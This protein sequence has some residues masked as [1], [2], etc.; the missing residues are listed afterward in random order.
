MKFWQQ[1]IV[2]I[3]AGI[4]LFI[5]FGPKQS[6]PHNPTIQG[7]LLK[8]GDRVFVFGGHSMNPKWLDGKEGYAGILEQFI[9]GQN[10]MPAAVIRMNESITAE[11]ISGEVL[12]LSLRYANATWQ[13]GAIVHLE[14]C[15]FEPDSTQ[16]QDRRKGK[17]IE[18]A[19]SIRLLKE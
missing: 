4:M 18:S 15:D 9:P 10:E 1:F 16:W 13:S 14:L 7:I 8:Q 19:A 6:I 2:V 11:G 3:I 5:F 17:W 12:V